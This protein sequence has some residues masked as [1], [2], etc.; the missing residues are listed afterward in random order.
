MNQNDYTNKAFEELSKIE[1]TRK[2]WY[3]EE[4]P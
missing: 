2:K 4:N 3:N 1:S